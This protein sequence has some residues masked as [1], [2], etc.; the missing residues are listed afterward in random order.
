MIRFRVSGAARYEKRHIVE[1]MSE[2]RKSPLLLAFAVLC[3]FALAACGKDKVAEKYPNG[4]PKIIRTYGFF[5]G[6]TPDN[7]QREQ[8]FFFNENKESDGRWNGGKLHGAYEDYWHNGQKKSH[9][10]YR[11]GLKQGIWEFWYNQFTLSSRGA[12]MDDR[13]EGPWSSQWENGTLK[14][15]GDFKGGK[16][17]G[18]WKEWTA[19]GE[20]VSVNSC[21]EANDTGRFVSY[22]ANNT[23][24]EEYTCRKGVPEGTYI[25]KDPDGVTVE[26]GAFDGQGRKQGLWEAWFSEGKAASRKGYAAGLDHDSAWAWDEAGRL[27]ERAW[28]DSGTGERLGYD[29]LGNIIERTRFKKGQPDGESWFFWPVVRAAKGMADKPGPKRQLVVYALG[30]PTTMQKWHSNGKPMAVGQ[31]ADGHRDGEWKDWWEDG[32]LKE[33]S[34]F[35]AGALHGERLFYDPKGK[36]MRT[37]RYEHGY[38]AEGRIPKGLGGRGK[39]AAKDSLAGKPAP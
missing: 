13:K 35:Q 7:L 6:A 18:T 4:K 25:K 15:Q 39:S 2:S 23:V 37:S 16:E 9:G 27:K 30:K 26:Q 3:I 28:F 8:R 33:I 11:E 34:R 24:K 20:A 12:F 17:T 31:F 5:G 19:K 21:F 29:T 1:S 32:T 22:H 36:L 14:S 10:E 38:P